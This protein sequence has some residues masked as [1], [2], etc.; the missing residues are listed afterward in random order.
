MSR[1]WVEVWRERFARIYGEPSSLPAPSG[2]AAP[3]RPDET[4]TGS[5]ANDYVV[6]ISRFADSGFSVLVRA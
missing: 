3:T 6:D 2:G 1:D 5:Y 4:Y